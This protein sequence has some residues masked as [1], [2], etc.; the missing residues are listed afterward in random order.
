MDA[1]EAFSD[2]GSHTEQVGALCRPVA[3]RTGAV[4]LACKNDQGYPAFSVLHAGVE[5]GHLLAFRKKPSDA[6]FRAGREFITQAD[7]GKGAADHGFVVAAPRSIRIEVGRLHAIL[8][9]V[10]S[11]WSAGLDV[12]GR[13]DMVGG[14][15]IAE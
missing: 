3:R 6:A 7:I 15:G 8:R 4:L 10:L 11:C 2:D 5:D 12:A 1:L 13:R 14:N 9:E